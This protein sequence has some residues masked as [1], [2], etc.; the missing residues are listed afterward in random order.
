MPSKPQ[1]CSALL[2]C[3]LAICGGVW[4]VRFQVQPLEN[5]SSL[6]CT[7]ESLENPVNARLCELQDRIGIST[8]AHCATLALQLLFP[9]PQLVMGPPTELTRGASSRTLLYQVVRDGNSI[10]MVAKVAALASDE[11][12]QVDLNN[13][14]LGENVQKALDGM[15]TQELQMQNKLHDLGLAPK[16]YGAGQCVNNRIAASPEVTPMNYDHSGKRAHVGVVVMDAPWTKG[17]TMISLHKLLQEL[18]LCARHA[19]FSTCLEISGTLEMDKS[20]QC[21]ATELLQSALCKVQEIWE[22]G[23]EIFNLRLDKFLVDTST[24]LPSGQKNP[25]AHD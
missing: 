22:Q 21:T 2:A 15:W 13:E 20:Q 25:K 9:I 6:P 23:I 12:T 19:D 16:A 18:V 1:R 3:L 11:K 10:P 4:G 8:D 24:C 17:K 7:K 5:Q 14:I